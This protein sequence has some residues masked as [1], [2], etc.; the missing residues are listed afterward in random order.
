MPL[1]ILK[2]IVK[3]CNISNTAQTCA[4]LKET[5]NKNKPNTLKKVS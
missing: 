1:T 4:E 2:D 3:N 5:Q